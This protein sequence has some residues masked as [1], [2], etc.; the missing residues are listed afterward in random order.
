MQLAD[1]RQVAGLVGNGDDDAV[2]F[3]PLH[4]AD[5][6]RTAQRH[7]RVELDDQPIRARLASADF[8]IQPHQLRIIHRGKVEGHQ[9]PSCASAGTLLFYRF[10]GAEQAHAI[11]HGQGARVARQTEVFTAS[12]ACQR[13]AVVAKLRVQ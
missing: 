13:G 1:S 8:R 4:D 2:V 11:D 3:Q 12:H 9:D 6:F 7:V 10:E 5:Q